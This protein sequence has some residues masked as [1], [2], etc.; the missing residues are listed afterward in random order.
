MLQQLSNKLEL[1][2]FLLSGLL[3]TVIIGCPSWRLCASFIV[4]LI[5]TER[6]LRKGFGFDLNLRNFLLIQAL[7]ILWLVIVGTSKIV[8]AQT[9]N[10]DIFPVLV[11]SSLGMLGYPVALL[12]RKAVFPIAAFVFIFAEIFIG[13]QTLFS[14]TIATIIALSGCYGMRGGSRRNLLLGG[15]A[16]GLGYLLWI[17][18]SSNSSNMSL[19][20]FSSAF[21]DGI[22]VA[23][24]SSFLAFLAVTAAEF[25]GFHTNLRL[26]EIGDLNHP[27][28][29]RLSLEA[30]GTWNHS[31]LMGMMAEAAAVKVGANGVLCRVGAYFHDIGKVCKPAYFVENNSRDT[32]L[33]DR[34]SP[35]MSAL[36]IKSHVKD[37]I[38]LGNE[39]RLPN[40]IIDIIKEHH[41]TSVVRYF[42]HQA[43][44]KN[45]EADVNTF[46]YDG[47]KPQS[48]ESA[49]VMLADSVEAASRSLIDPSADQIRHLV[50]SIID[51]ILRSGELSNVELT[52]KQLDMIAA[53]FVS[54]LIGI[55]H[56]RIA[57]NMRRS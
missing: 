11:F 9:F 25:L 18:A 35:Y 43:K 50:K 26:I 20:A 23:F 5:T 56:Q 10:G 4:F 57:Y 37:G 24:C 44:T 53:E 52:F 2:Y 22:L 41:G 15:G 51:D 47:P 55:K 7:T 30:S 46:R 32:S 29:R 48:L 19:L 16:S 45:P 33:H 49:I 28:L 27:L 13:I 42:Y 17:F 34:L 40:S 36:V 39:Y 1:V 8:F 12:N 3:G 21:F 6:I 31:I 54:V 38:R 14:L